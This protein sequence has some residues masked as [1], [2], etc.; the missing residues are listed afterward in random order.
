MNIDQLAGRIANRMAREI[1]YESTALVMD[2]ICELPRGDREA[3]VIRLAQEY[4][5]LHA[6]TAR[7]WQEKAA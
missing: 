1:G 4:G 2:G 7:E 6:D 5:L 3:A